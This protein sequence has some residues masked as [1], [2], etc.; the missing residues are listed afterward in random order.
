MRQHRLLPISLFCLLA[1]PVP[2][3]VFAQSEQAPRESQTKRLLSISPR[4]PRG[5]TFGRARRPS[6]GIRQS[7]GLS[8]AS[9]VDYSSGGTDAG[10]VVAA[11]VNADR[12]IDLVVANGDSIGVLIGNGDGTFQSAVPYA[13]PSGGASGIAVADVNGDG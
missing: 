12:K 13:L 9:A 6:A 4:L 1:I 5:I 2:G 3:L 8:F 10:I 7:S 11:D